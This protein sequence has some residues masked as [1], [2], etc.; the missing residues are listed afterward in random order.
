LF[1]VEALHVNIGHALQDV[2]IPGAVRVRLLDDAQGGGVG[3][4]RHVEFGEAVI[5]IG[6][7]KIFVDG[8]VHQAARHELINQAR[9]GG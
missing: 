6:Q 1:P 5:N 7:F 4:A 9:A 2:D 3:F 8:F